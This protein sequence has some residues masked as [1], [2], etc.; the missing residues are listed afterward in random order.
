M[1]LNTDVLKGEISASAKCLM[2]SCVNSYI[3]WSQ[4]VCR[5]Y[6]LAKK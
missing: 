2:D 6:L 1:E 4:F 3:Y 5:P